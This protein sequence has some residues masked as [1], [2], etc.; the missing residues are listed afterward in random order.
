MEMEIVS[1]FHGILLAT[2]SLIYEE[3]LIY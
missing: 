2:V 1:Q 3:I